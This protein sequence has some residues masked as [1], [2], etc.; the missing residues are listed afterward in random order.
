MRCSSKLIHNHGS[1]GYTAELQLK[2]SAPLHYR[3]ANVKTHN[4]VVLVIFADY[5]PEGILWQ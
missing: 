5:Y 2:L 3:Y 4:V 1:V